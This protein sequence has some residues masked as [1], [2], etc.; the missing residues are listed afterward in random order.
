MRSGQAE[1]IFRQ[2]YEEEQEINLQLQ[3][4]LRDL[5]NKLNHAEL[6]IDNNLKARDK[7]LSQF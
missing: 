5:K 3:D 7:L 6:T 4:E 2:K 1:Q